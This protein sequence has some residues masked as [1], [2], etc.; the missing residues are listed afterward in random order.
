MSLRDAL[1]SRLYA[2]LY[3]PRGLETL[4]QLVNRL[5]SAVVQVLA[6]QQEW[7][8]EQPA[9]ADP[10]E[11]DFEAASIIAAA[12]GLKAAQVPGLVV[13][14]STMRVDE[15]TLTMRD[16]AAAFAA[17]DVPPDVAKRVLDR[18]LRVERK[19]FMDGRTTI[20]QLRAW[21]AKGEDYKA[22]HMIVVCDTFKYEDFPVYVLRGAH[23]HEL[24]KQHSEPIAKMLKVMEVYSYGR[25]LEEQLREH[26]AYHLD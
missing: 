2:E 4:D 26:R 24:V 15:H 18:A 9:A 6:E 1:K 16:V 7:Q 20:E 25:D 5:A 3:G 22:T 21:L 23:V 12:G 13:L 11:R 10:S 17:E 14:L 19:S 8:L